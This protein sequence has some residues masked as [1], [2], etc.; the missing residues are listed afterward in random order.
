[1]PAMKRALE[2]LKAFFFFFYLTSYRLYW[3]AP[4]TPTK[5]SLSV[6]KYANR[7]RV[8]RPSEFKKTNQDLKNGPF[9]VGSWKNSA[10]SIYSH[11]PKFRFSEI[12]SD[13]FSCWFF[14]F[15]PSEFKNSF[16]TH[17]LDRRSWRPR[18]WRSS[19]V[20]QKGKWRTY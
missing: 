11:V 15:R 8:F 16:N 3:G 17:F 1:M 5:K 10:F 14:D 6:F 19:P 12:S 20:V 9:V 4:P 18:K 7:D 2:S 13:I